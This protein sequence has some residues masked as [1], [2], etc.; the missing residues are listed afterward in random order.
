MNSVVK[1]R[2]EYPRIFRQMAVCIITQGTRTWYIGI[3]EVRFQKLM[4]LTLVWNVPRESPKA[5]CTEVLLKHV[6]I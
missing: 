5:V 3:S 2:N 6:F 4:I 1:N